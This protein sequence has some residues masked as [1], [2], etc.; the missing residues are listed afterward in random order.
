M[1]KKPSIRSLFWYEFKPLLWVTAL[2]SVVFALLGFFVNMTQ[3]YDSMLQNMIFNPIVSGA[4]GYNNYFYFSNMFNYGLWALA[5]GAMAALYQQF[6]FYRASRARLWESLPYTR[7]QAHPPRV[8][9]GLLALAIPFVLSMLLLSLSLPATLR[10]LNEYAVASPFFESATQIVT[11][12]YPLSLLLKM[13][14]MALSAYALTSFIAGL[15]GNAPAAAAY[16]GFLLLAAY[17]AWNGGRWFLSSLTELTHV[18]LF[19]TISEKLTVFFLT[20]LCPISGYNSALMPWE[21]LWFFLLCHAIVIFTFI[22]LGFRFRRGL[23]LEKLSETFLFTTSRVAVVVLAGGIALFAAMGA[24][25]PLPIYPPDYT[26]HLI[27]LAVVAAITFV[28]WY[29]VFRGVRRKRVKALSLTLLMLFGLGC[30]AAARAEEAAPHVAYDAFVFDADTLARQWALTQAVYGNGDEDAHPS[31]RYDEFLYAIQAQP[32]QWDYKAYQYFMEDHRYR[33]YGP[34]EPLDITLWAEQMR[35]QGFTDAADAFEKTYAA[36]TAEAS[37]ILSQTYCTSP[38]GFSLYKE[39]YAMQGKGPVGASLLLGLPVSI[40]GAEKVESILDAMPNMLKNM[41]FHNGSVIYER[42]TLY[43]KTLHANEKYLRDVDFALIL[44]TQGHLTHISLDGSQLSRDEVF[45]V[46]AQ[47]L[48]D[49]PAA[50]KRAK[51]IAA[52]GGSAEVDGV[53][54]DRIS[55]GVLTLKLE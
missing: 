17:L 28:T 21:G 27:S 36:M 4:W 41:A 18:S 37:T 45:D 53:Q 46:L 12:L 5:L 14:A 32:S 26:P 9:A 48:P 44:D 35:V 19:E 7:N 52:S 6:L 11:L 34:D 13:L 47:L 15:F 40:K 33:W 51:E 25:A 39:D 49:R 55:Y 2:G 42:Y 23:A 29:I 43:A 1:Q 16:C 54:I 30:H 8:A 22:P 31:L 24:L 38:L 3:G 10:R 20:V 50:L